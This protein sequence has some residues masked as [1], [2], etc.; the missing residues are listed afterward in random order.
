MSTTL[1]KA[2]DVVLANRLCLGEYT[3]NILVVVLLPRVIWF[4]V[5]SK[6]RLSCLDIYKLRCILTRITNLL[7]RSRYDIVR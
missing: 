7:I 5:E 1:L 6:L 3:G 2:E 4:I